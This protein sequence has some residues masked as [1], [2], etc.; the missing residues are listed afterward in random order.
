MFGIGDNLHQRAVVVELL[1]T[2]EVWLE[3]C[4]VWIYRDLLD[5]GLK[6]ILRPTTL[7]THARNIEREKIEYPDAYR[8]LRS[9]PR[10]TRT[11][12]NGYHRRGVEEH[13]SVI[14]SMFATAG[15]SPPQHIDF[16]L[17][18]RPEW[19]SSRVHTI[20]SSARDSGKPLM[21]YRPVVLRREWPSH[22]R[23]PDPV[24]YAALYESIRERFYVVSVASIVPNVEWIVGAEQ[25]ADLKIH[26]GSLS[27]PEMAALFSK[28]DVVF[29]NGGMAPVLAQA[30]GT[31]SIVVYGG[32]ECFDTTH[33]L[34]AKL[35]PT[36]PI[37][38][39][40]PCRCFT[41]NCSGCDKRID[42]ESAV[43][44]IR[45]FVA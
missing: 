43:T 19:L 31:P 39:D 4:H 37:D 34:G 32:Y 45:E 7:Y 22:L 15:L 8:D 38:T 2:Y 11:V 25:P 6:L 40:A 35:T 42:V 12:R 21:V 44:R 27:M 13:G 24:A 10:S 1:K 17:T 18:I 30:V 20:V 9:I 28:A 36:L 41:N 23:N 16:R 14:Q 5:S 3:T 33:A 26:D 29:C